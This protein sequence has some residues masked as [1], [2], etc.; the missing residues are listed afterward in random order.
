MK[1]TER[2]AELRRLREEAL[3]AEAERA[4]A[5]DKVREERK[6]REAH[7][8]YLKSIADDLSRPKEPGVSRN[9]GG[10]VTKRMDIV[11]KINHGGKRGRGRP[12]LLETKMSDAE[13]A[14]RY[15]ARKKAE[16][17]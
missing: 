13:R 7:Y 14:R 9:N 5:E 12:P 17:K 1:P 8:R 15:R 3:A 10:I 11:T 2:E 4:I 16:G 6:A